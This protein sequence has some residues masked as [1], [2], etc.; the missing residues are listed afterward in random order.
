MLSGVNI[1]S[2]ALAACLVAMRLVMDGLSVALYRVWSQLLIMSQLDGFLLHL[3]H[4]PP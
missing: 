4:Q 3:K 1:E 2:G